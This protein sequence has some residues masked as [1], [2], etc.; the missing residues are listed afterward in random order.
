MEKPILKAA[1]LIISDTAFQ[2]PSTDKA[3]DV[4]SDVFTNEGNGQWTVDLRKIIPDDVLEIQKAVT[5]CCDREDY[6][7][8]LI[9][10]GGTGFA[11]KDNTPEAINALIHRHAPGLV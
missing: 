10:T 4:L 9:T 7:N 5:L 3:G 8:L 2:D 11:V 6:V 1:I